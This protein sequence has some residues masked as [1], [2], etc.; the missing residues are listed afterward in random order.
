MLCT[1]LRR[2]C[3]RIVCARLSFAWLRAKGKPLSDIV[4]VKQ[5]VSWPRH[6]CNGKRKHGEGAVKRGAMKEEIGIGHVSANAEPKPIADARRCDRQH[7]LSKL[8][9]VDIDRAGVV[10]VAVLPH[11]LPPLLRPA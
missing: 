11:G 10:V 9:I 6:S 4:F 3:V 2:Q 1:V 7:F 8:V 5:A